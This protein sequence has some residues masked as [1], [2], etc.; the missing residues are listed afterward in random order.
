MPFKLLCP[1]NSSNLQTPQILSNFQV[2]PSQTSIKLSSLSKCQFC[3]IF[4]SLKP[5]NLCNLYASPFTRVNWVGG[6]CNPASQPM[7]PHPKKC[8]P[9]QRQRTPLRGGLNWLAWRAQQQR[10]WHAAGQGVRVY[11]WLHHQLLLSGLGCQQRGQHCRISENCKKCPGTT[12]KGHHAC[13]GEK[14]RASAKVQVL[15]NT[16][17]RLR[18]QTP[19]MDYEMNPEHWDESWAHFR[20]RRFDSKCIL[21]DLNRISKQYTAWNRRRRNARVFVWNWFRLYLASHCSSGCTGTIL[22]YHQL[23]A[24]DH[25]SLWHGAPTHHF[26]LLWAKTHATGSR[27]CQGVYASRC[28]FGSLSNKFVVAIPSHGWKPEKL[29]CSVIPVWWWR[30]WWLLLL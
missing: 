9:T 22:G 20:S 17:D 11:S 18:D 28:I 14:A 15:D 30:W 4:K 2:T 1:S 29:R 23:L 7:Q 21:E 27:Q 5:A 3:Q 24:R 16:S 25:S 12:C 13:P 10:G 19:A 8:V 6:S 26:S